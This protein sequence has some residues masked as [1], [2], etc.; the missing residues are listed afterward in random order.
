MFCS[1]LCMDG[2][3][4]FRVP[5]ESPGTTTGWNNLCLLQNSELFPSSVLIE[6]F[7]LEL[8]KSL[9]LLNVHGPYSHQQG[10][11]LEFFSR[12]YLKSNE[13]IVGRDLNFILQQG[14]VWAELGRMDSLS[15]F[16]LH[17]LEESKL[18]NLKPL[19]LVLTW[20][21]NRVGLEGISKHLDRFLLL[22]SL[23]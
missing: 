2:S 5:L 12:D 8:G 7:S 20:Q 19:K 23:M 22:E 10:F 21:N 6:I 17:K 16:L 1:Q 9:T 15:T 13:L 4:L 3:L 18:C 14:E 11:W